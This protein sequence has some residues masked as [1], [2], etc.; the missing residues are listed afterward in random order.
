MSAKNK[1]FI[2]LGFAITSF[3]IYKCTPTTE[4]IIYP[5]NYTILFFDKT[6]SNSSSYGTT[7]IESHKNVIQKT[8]DNLK[9]KGD[10]IKT[11]Y[12]DAITESASN[13][14]PAAELD[15]ESKID[16]NTGYIDQQNAQ[17]EFDRSLYDLK[18]KT[19]KSLL[20]HFV[21]NGNPQNA[22]YT[23]TWGIINKLKTEARVLKEGDKMEILIFSDMEESMI[24]PGRR[25]FHKNQIQT[26]EDANKLAKEDIEQIKKIYSLD[27]IPF[28]ENIKV[29]LYFPAAKLGKAQMEAYWTRVF[30]DFN[31]SVELI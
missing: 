30:N 10:K 26:I 5:N 21:N 6:L 7:E 11:F 31:I 18:N 17:K 13:M 15:F 23:D 25:D 12:I 20:H 22:T 24:A 14:T 28:A 27:S 3:V 29:K 1:I 2:I 9:V 8:T 19:K 16:M 4:P